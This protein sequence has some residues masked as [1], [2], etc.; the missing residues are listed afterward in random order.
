MNVQQ[1]ELPQELRLIYVDM[2]D[3][4][5]NYQSI[6][7]RKR[8]LLNIKNKRIPFWKSKLDPRD[9]FESGYSGLYEETQN[10]FN[11]LVG[12]ERPSSSRIVIQEIERVLPDRL[13]TVRIEQLEKEDELF[14]KAQEEFAKQ[15]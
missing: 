8:K 14:E 12:L 11:E 9:F 2:L 13:V 15:S 4:S 5:Q 6:L 10:I 3:K 7:E 1:N